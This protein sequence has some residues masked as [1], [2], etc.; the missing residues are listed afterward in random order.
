[1]IPGVKLPVVVVLPDWDGLNEVNTSSYTELSTY[2][3][4]GHRRTAEQLVL[5]GFASRRV[6]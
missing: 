5:V 2:G 6:Q 1:M 3:S 4:L